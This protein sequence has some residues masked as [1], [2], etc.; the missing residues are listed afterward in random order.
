MKKLATLILACAFPVAAFSQAGGITLNLKQENPLSKWGRWTY[1]SQEGLNYSLNLSQDR[2]KLPL[3]ANW[4]SG[5]W[6]FKL[7]KD[8]LSD[9]HDLFFGLKVNEADLGVTSV[10]CMSNGSSSITDALCGVQLDL[11]LQ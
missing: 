4:A 2:N 6:M 10:G 11:N 5:D 3:T 1:L 9:R 8:M 7:N